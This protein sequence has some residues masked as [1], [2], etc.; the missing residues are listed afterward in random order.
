MTNQ[1]MPKEAFGNDTQRTRASSRTF[2][3]RVT[4][5]WLLRVSCNFPRAMI[6]MKYVGSLIF[7]HDGFY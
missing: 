2:G 5:F 1:D 6:L 3:L 4:G 7:L